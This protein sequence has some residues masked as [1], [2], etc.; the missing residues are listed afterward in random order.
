MSIFKYGHFL[1]KE[2]GGILQDMGIL[3]KNKKIK[4]KY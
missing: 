1:I 4:K 2:I 3:H